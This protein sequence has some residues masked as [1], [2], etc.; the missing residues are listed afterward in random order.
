MYNILIRMIER[1]KYKTK[2]DM[3]YKLSILMLNEQITETEYKELML[4]LSE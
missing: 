3:E 2:E 1:K 4:M